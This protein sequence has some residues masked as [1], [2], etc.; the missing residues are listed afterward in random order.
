MLRIKNWDAIFENNRTR[1]LKNPFWFAMP[2]R[3]DSLG[4]RTLISMPNGP[5]LYGADRKS[6]V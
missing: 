5:A 2:N 4:Y 3:H 6:V 1:E